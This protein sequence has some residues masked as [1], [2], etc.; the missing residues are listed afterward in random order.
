MRKVTVAAVIVHV[1]MVTM[2][3]A[4]LGAARV[5]TLLLPPRMTRTARSE[6]AP[7]GARIE[8]WLLI[9]MA[10]V[11]AVVAVVAMVAA[12][13]VAVMTA[14]VVEA[15]VVPVAAAASP[16][17]RSFVASPPRA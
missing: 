17:V 5:K 3:M 8:Q 4:R 2:T 11:A 12:A 1:M 16:V 14:V 9:K 13:P 6:K 7:K 15:L 10:A